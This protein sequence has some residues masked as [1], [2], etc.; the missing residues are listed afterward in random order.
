MCTVNFNFGLSSSN[1]RALVV[2]C[3]ISI[4]VE[5][6][7][8]NDSVYMARIIVANGTCVLFGTEHEQG[9]DK[10]LAEGV[11][12]RGDNLVGE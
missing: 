11:P 1:D 9:G 5:A 4:G 8:S 3:G 7:L 6:I 12:L 10:A 2:R